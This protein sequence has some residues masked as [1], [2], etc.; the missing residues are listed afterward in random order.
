VYACSCPLYLPVLRPWQ[1]KHGTPLHKVLQ[2]RMTLSQL[3]RITETML[4]QLKEIQLLGPLST[5]RR[6][7]NFKPT[8]E[9][10]D[11]H[12]HD[13]EQCTEQFCPWWE[14]IPP[15]MSQDEHTRCIICLHYLRAYR[16]TTCR[17][18]TNALICGRCRHIML[19]NERRMEGVDA[20]ATVFVP[21]VICRQR[22]EIVRCP[23]WI[24]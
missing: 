11:L 24:Y 10:V 21:C 7:L 15:T 2:H 1:H 18:E 9:M 4:P 8:G 6:W 22:C 20:R 14:E 3:S 17:H 12:H 16:W 5:N 23:L 19:S 13:Q